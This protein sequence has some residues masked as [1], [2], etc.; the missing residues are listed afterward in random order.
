MGDRVGDR[1]DH[2]DWKIRV[3]ELDSICMKGIRS[4][5]KISAKINPHREEGRA[6]QRGGSR[7]GKRSVKT[8]APGVRKVGSSRKGSTQHE[9]L[10]TAITKR[11]RP[12]T[13]VRSGQLEIRTATKRGK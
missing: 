1:A 8:L 10:G 5:G 9:P 12:N 2:W 11:K 7:R 4:E 6:S 13:Y 3:E